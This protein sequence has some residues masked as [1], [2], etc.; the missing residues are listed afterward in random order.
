SACAEGN[1]IS[2][3]DNTYL[4]DMSTTLLRVDFLADK[5]GL[6]FASPLELYF[7]IVHFP[8]AGVGG[9]LIQPDESSTCY[10][11]Y[12]W[13]LSEPVTGIASFENPGDEPDLT[14]WQLG[15]YGLSVLPESDA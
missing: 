2:R 3:I 5:P 12:A 4:A 8:R 10:S 1:G 15:Q 14:Q 7:G 13:V 6:E 9:A 11:G